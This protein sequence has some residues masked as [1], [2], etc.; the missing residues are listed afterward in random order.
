MRD[1]A[2][3]QRLLCVEAGHPLNGLFGSSLLISSCIPLS[4]E[5][6]SVTCRASPGTVS[7]LALTSPRSCLVTAPRPKPVVRDPFFLFLGRSRPS[8]DVAFGP[9]G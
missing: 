9:V 3:E 4:P 2:S 6:V 5:V 7:D 1:V 8:S